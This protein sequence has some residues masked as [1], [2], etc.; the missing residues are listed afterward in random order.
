MITLP[1]L[2][3]VAVVAADGPVLHDSF[4]DG[5]AT[6]TWVVKDLPADA[7]RV[8]ETNG[9][10]ECTFAASPPV[11]SWAGYRSNGWALA[12]TSDIRAKVAFRF[13]PAL[14]TFELGGLGL[15][16]Y[17]IGSPQQPSGMF[18]GYLLW[19]GSETVDESGYR[20]ASLGLVNA[21]GGFEKLVGYWSQIGDT[22]MYDEGSWT[23]AF[24]LPSTGTMYLRYVA[25]TDTV[26]V[27]FVG[28]ESTTG[29]G[30]ANATQGQHRPWQLAFGGRVEGS[31]ALAGSDA[32]FDDL[33]VE[34]GELIWSDTP[35]L[36]WRIPASGQ[37]ALS[38]LSPTGTSSW[39][40]VGTVA[41]LSGWR[42][43][44]I[45]DF[46]ADGNADIFWRN[47]LTGT[48]YI[49]Y[50]AG[51]NLLGGAV[52]PGVGPASGW[53]PQVVGDL[54]GDCYADLVW[55]HAPD[56]TYLLWLMQGPVIVGGGS[57]GTPSP[58]WS[59]AAAGDINRDGR[60]DLIW[61]N[62]S[63]ANYVW[64]MN[65]AS[66]LGG[67][68]LPFLSPLLG[69]ALQGAIDVNR[70]G[71]D[72]LVWRHQVAGTTVVWVMNGTNLGSTMTLAAT[73]PPWT[74]VGSQ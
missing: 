8:S 11:L 22:T 15:Q 4:A 24:D 35:E 67:A 32:W 29:V 21:G 55:K 62:A 38:I 30:V 39:L 20:V 53:T 57:L 10:L 50:L 54:N 34:V 16:T 36:L 13:H 37:V 25:A 65:G 26:Y 70:D 63:G 18:E 51:G 43:Y 1:L 73:N 40:P 49:W 17:T 41:P 19:F 5:K 2:A 58:A 42:A 47:I 6:P 72:D 45:G 46:N 23:P 64:Y 60:D 14:P 71:E 74:I 12:T 7:V 68:S 66:L 44:G 27:S 56:G 59:L 28:Y 31:V 61:R 9:R 69:W 52:P 3:A 33:V 48:N